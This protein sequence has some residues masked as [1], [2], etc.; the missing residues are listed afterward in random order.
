MQMEKDIL[1]TTQ[2]ARLLG[3]SV[4]TAQ[5]LIEGGSLP[6]WKTPGGHRRVH[7]SDVAALMAGGAP[8]PVFASALVIVL[9]S[10]E[11]LPLY[12]NTLSTVGEC[13]ADIYSDV[14]SASFAIGS[15]LPAAVIIDLEDRKTERLSLLHSLTSN[16]ALGRTHIIAVGARDAA[17]AA[18]T[19]RGQSSNGQ[20]SKM[21]TCIELLENLPDAVR[22][23]LRDEPAY[24][25]EGIRSFPLPANEGQ[26]LQ[27]LERSGLV[28]TAPEESFDRLTWL[29]SY[30]L[31]M[32][33]ALMTLL[34]PTRQWFKSHHG[35]DMAE[36]PRD[37]AFCN[38]TILQKKVNAIENL[39]LDARFA[40]NPAVAGGPNFRFYAGAPVVDPDGFALGSL[41]VIDYEPRRL[42]Q[43]QTQTLLALAG[44]ASDEVR[45][46]AADR[47]MRW[48]LE[49]LNRA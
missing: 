45:L 29:A 36:T 17:E 26:R 20:S 9:A 33:I 18:S 47:Q 3:V 32:P 39:A 14:N 48:S 8:A 13:A 24:M 49:A 16:P 5:L 31:E 19:G 12:K 41:C 7:R 40:A 38:Y 34:T 44:L 27:A 25:A 43:A 21:V 15:H 11:R 2:A 22:T 10:P 23:I 46:R 42:D 37:W 28:D 6:S 30:S 4:R 35:L 1:T